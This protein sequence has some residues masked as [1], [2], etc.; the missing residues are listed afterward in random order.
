[1]SPRWQPIRRAEK[2]ALGATVHNNAPQRNAIGAT[3]LN[4]NVR[5]HVNALRTA[6]AVF[7]T[8]GALAFGAAFVISFLNSGVVERIA[9]DIIRYEVEKRVREKINS[10]DSEF[11]TQRAGRF[12]KGYAAEISAAKRQL[13][14]GLTQRLATVIAEMQNLDC[15]C[16]RKIETSIR[17]GFEWRI[18][19]ASQ[20]TDRLNTLVRTKYMETAAKL[21]REFRVFT[22][23]NAIVFALLAFATLI[24]RRAGLHLVP[25]AFVLVIAASLT[26]YLYLFNQNW[27]HTIIFSDYL[28]FGFVAYLSV[29]FVF[30]CDIIFNH[31]RITTRLLNR[32]LDA[33][34]SAASLVP[35]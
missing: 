17:G 6:L 13:T 10:I 18:S 14:D 35:C 12:I 23:T 28:G 5:G 1:M 26:A 31:G 22:G 20:A 30:L 9:K 4:V 8:T 16:R 33:V 29:A 11:L 15:E 32:L 3:R 27:L 21:T 25:P 34:G 7:G 2:C 19:A 24:K